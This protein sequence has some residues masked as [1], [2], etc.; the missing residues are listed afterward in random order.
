M[1]STEQRKHLHD[2]ME[3]L[4]AYEPQVDYPTS[5]VRGAKDAATFALTETQMKA[6]LAAGKHLM[7]DCSGLTTDIF[8]WAK[9]KDPNGLSYGHQGYTGTM[10]ATLPHY[11]DA[12]GSYVGAL[13]VFGPGTGDHVA[14]VLEPDH[15]HG[16]PMLFS[17]GFEG[18]PVKVSLNTEAAGHR[19]PVTMLSIS[20]LG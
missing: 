17:H 12:R 7:G 19:P 9:L 13:A 8:R 15:V 1:T 5:D 10:L 20:S 14:I 2:L 16:N 18:G 4:L 11:K 3:L 6:A